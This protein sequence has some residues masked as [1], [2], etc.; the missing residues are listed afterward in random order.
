MAA[1]ESAESVTSI[2]GAEDAALLVLLGI[3]AMAY[4]GYGEKDG[5]YL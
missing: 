2:A 3:F 4:C 5:E 1:F